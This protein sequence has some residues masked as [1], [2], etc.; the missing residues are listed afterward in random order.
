MKVVLFLW[1][2]IQ[3]AQGSYDRV[4]LCGVNMHFGPH[5][6]YKNRISNLSILISAGYWEIT[7]VTSA[8]SS[9]L[10][11]WAIVLGW[12]SWGLILWG[13]PS[14]LHQKFT[15]ATARMSHASLWP[16][17]SL[18]PGF[19]SHI[20]GWGNHDTTSVPLWTEGLSL[21]CPELLSAQIGSPHF[22]Q[23]EPREFSYFYFISLW[24][25][26]QHGWGKNIKWI[27]E[28]KNPFLSQKTRVWNHG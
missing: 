13:S 15:P 20:M 12:G 27:K 7:P 21:R 6:V 14:G 24:R 18:L 2:N 26:L 3:R 16:R 25:W 9:F 1:K 4:D 23:S 19:L 22:S 11:G 28:E 5:L 8:V 17:S 10:Q